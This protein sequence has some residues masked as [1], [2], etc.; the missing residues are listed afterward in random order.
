MFH[1]LQSLKLM[2]AV[3]P[4]TFTQNR[5]EDSS[6]LLNQLLECVQDCQK[7][8]GGKKE[9]AT[10]FDSCVAAL[11]LTLEAVFLHG[12]RI[13][14]HDIQQL[15]AL[16]QVSEIVSNSLHLGND[17]LCNVFCF[18]SFVLWQSALQSINLQLFYDELFILL[19][20]SVRFTALVDI[21]LFICSILA[22][23]KKALDQARTRKIHNFEACLDR[24]RKRKGLVEIIVEWTLI[25]KVILCA[26]ALTSLYYI[27]NLGTSILY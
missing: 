16:Q 17:T 4:T 24:Y 21:Y 8:F 9:L 13:K 3:I 14:P 7:R 26:F 11:C 6:K 20:V 10:E 19:S 27:V 23:C 12:L 25:R 1:Y 22:F 5:R 2:S 15:S 18:G